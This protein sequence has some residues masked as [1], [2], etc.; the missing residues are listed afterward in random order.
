MQNK[1]VFIFNYLENV[2]KLKN[3]LVNLQHS[4]ETIYESSNKLEKI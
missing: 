4:T 3:K 2:W 1:L